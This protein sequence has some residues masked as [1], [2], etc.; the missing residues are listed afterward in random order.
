MGAPEAPYWI[1]IAA[2]NKRYPSLRPERDR[3]AI[4][5]IIERLE[6]EYPTTGV[7]D[8]DA[9]YTWP[10]RWQALRD[11]APDG[12]ERETRALEEAREGLLRISDPHRS[13]LLV[14]DQELALKY[15]E[16]VDAILN[17]G[18]EE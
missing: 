5:D 10:E 13:Q 4:A 8:Q 11:V 2:W 9:R 15:T 3:E 1:P 6:D 14:T 12:R 17:G 7:F 16:R 18:L